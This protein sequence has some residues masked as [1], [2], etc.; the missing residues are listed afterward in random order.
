MPRLPK[1]F[2]KG[3]IYKLVCLD[4]NVK[5]IYVGSTTNFVERKKNHKCSCNNSNN[6][7]YNFK[8]YQ[9]IRQHG[10]W[11]NFNMVL[12][13]YYPCET[14]L[15]LGRREDYWKQELQASLNSISPPM[16]KTRKE[17]WEEY[18]EAHR[19]QYNERSK[20]YWENNKE[21]LQKKKNEKHT[22]ECGGKYSH[23]HKTDHYK[24]KKHQ[25]YLAENKD[26]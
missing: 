22:C 4:L 13:E 25:N 1:D 19:Q 6:K 9:H 12:I 23:S 20:E 10:G 16:Y 2:S 11:T 24:T 5:E 7:N 21:Q 18:Y 8:V 15:E 26:K 3:L 14:D 17:Y